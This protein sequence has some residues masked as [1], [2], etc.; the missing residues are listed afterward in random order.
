MDR[1]LVDAYA[2]LERDHW[3]FR[4]RRRVLDAVLDRTLREPPGRILVAGCGPAG[5]LDWLRP[6]G[7][8]VGVDLEP[9]FASGAPPGTFLRARAELL[10]FPDRSFGA[11]CAFDVIEHLDDDA[12]ALRE[13][14]RVTR[15]PLVV[16]VPALPFLWGPH[17]EVNRHR[18]RYTRRTL[19]D[20]FHRARLEPESIAWFNFLLLPPIAAARLGGRLARRRE[21]RSD[22]SR[23]PS[24][25]LSRALA[26]I[27]GFERHLVGRVPVPAGVS[28]VAV[29]RI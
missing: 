20:A 18:R 22:F 3:W 14:A 19:R 26:A 13:L 15:G 27:F 17:D 23:V 28:L 10:P 5:G 25:G 6:R 29:A 1:E 21:P 11:T 2:Q 4:G 16:T 7:E 9:G 8:V 24:A 12:A